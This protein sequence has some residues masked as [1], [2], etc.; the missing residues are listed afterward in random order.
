MLKNGKGSIINTGSMS[1]VIVNRPQEQCHYNTAK[2][3]VHHLTKSLACEWATRGVRV[4]SVAPTYIETSL[5]SFAPPECVEAWKKDT[6]Q[7]RLGQPREI[8]S[9]VA[10]LASDAASLITGDVL[11]A[12]GG[13][14]CW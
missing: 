13:F 2:A 6:P 4:N 14:T 7:A 8:G 1:G 9:V 3:A 11:L 10:F 5:L 12:D